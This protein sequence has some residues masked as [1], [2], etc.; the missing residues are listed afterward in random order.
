MWWIAYRELIITTPSLSEC[1]S[2]VI[3]YDETLHQQKKD[4]TSFVKAITD[5]GMIPGIKVDTISSRS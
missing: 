3:L 2:G 4:G 5:A 1:I